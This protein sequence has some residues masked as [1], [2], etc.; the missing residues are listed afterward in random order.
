MTR[1]LA[2]L[3]A[4]LFLAAGCSKKPSDPPP[5]GGGGTPAGGS[6]PNGSGGA[7]E[8]VETKWTAAALSAAHAKELVAGRSKFTGKTVE[9]SGEVLD[10]QGMGHALD[11]PTRVVLRGVPGKG[12]VVPD[13]IYF[14]FPDAQ[15]NADPRLYQL[16][17]GQKFTARGTIEFGTD[18]VLKDC[19][20]LSVGPTTAVPTTLREIDKEV[21]ADGKDFGRFKD[22]DV[23]VKATIGGSQGITKGGRGIDCEVQPPAGGKRQVTFRGSS[24]GEAHDKE[25]AKLKVG[26]SVYLLARLEVPR[27]GV[28]PNIITFTGARLLKSLPEGVTLPDE[29]K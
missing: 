19:A 20:V 4:L 7:A 22:R 29:K 8:V 25:L 17:L 23:I 26:D 13:G 24:F 11:E 16:T 5:A 2:S 10:V 15:F 14:K 27:F 28:N 1:P 12:E 9:V 6:T 21:S 3:L 18:L